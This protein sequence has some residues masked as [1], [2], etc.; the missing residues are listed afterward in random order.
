MFNISMYIYSKTILGKRRGSE[1][2]FSWTRLQI[3]KNH[4][5][6]LQTQLLIVSHYLLSKK[7]ANN[8]N[9]QKISKIFR[10]N[11]YFELNLTEKNQRRPI[12][13]WFDHKP[14]VC[15]I[16]ESFDVMIDV[17]YII[18]AT[19]STVQQIWGRATIIYGDEVPKGE[20]HKMNLLPQMYVWYQLVL[21][22]PCDSNSFF[23]ENSLTPTHF[24]LK[25]SWY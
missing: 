8:M 7:Q 20:K 19:F 5:V 10:E 18:I 17:K 9:L 13:T 2:N 15:D 21:F 4:Y 25:K 22:K 24:S 16:M 11:R 23:V 14:Q 3:S 1:N 12:N 6:T